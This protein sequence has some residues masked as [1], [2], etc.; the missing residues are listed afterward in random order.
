MRQAQLA[1]LFVLPLPNEGA[2]DASAVVLIMD[3]GK[4]N[5]YGRIDYGGCMRAKNASEC[6]HN[7]LAFSL[8]QRFHI[9]NEP[10]P[11]FQRR[12]N[13][14]HFHL[15][16]HEERTVAMQYNNH[17]H[18]MKRILGSLDIHTSKKT[19]LNRGG[20]ARHAEDSGASEGDIRRAGRWNVQQ[21]Q[22]CYLT[23]LP[24]KA[25]RALA[26]FPT[27][28][29]A[30]HL[31]RATINP[32]PAL[33]NK[34][35][36]D[37]EGA[38]LGIEQG[39][40]EKDLAAQG[41][42]RLLVYLRTVLVQDAVVMRKQFSQH[43]IFQHTIFADPLFIDYAKNLE[44]ALDKNER[45]LSV[46]VQE[47]LPEAHR[48]LLDMQRDQQAAHLVTQ[49]TNSTILQLAGLVQGAFTSI[50][51][52]VD[53]LA[54]R[55]VKV[56]VHIEQHQQRTGSSPVAVAALAQSR[57]DRL[58]ITSNEDE[59]IEHH[60]ESEQQQQRS[61]QPPLLLPSP[62]SS[63][64][65]QSPAFA[66][67]LRGAAAAAE[68]E[69][70]TVPIFQQSRAL[71]SIVHVWQEYEKGINHGP[72]VRDLEARWQHKWRTD[73]KSRKFFSQRNKIYAKVMRLAHDKRVT[74][75]QAA[76]ALENARVA[77]KRSVDWCQKNADTL[78]TATISCLR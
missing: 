17:Y 55:E 29:G 10:F 33:L 40:L 4:T 70:E 39:R 45:P 76:Q 54:N 28:P 20:A 60:V 26:G 61:E 53:S 43:P 5:A 27:K 19:H 38:L 41:F 71:T 69:E 75:V 49:H 16:V 67:P 13:W 56:T 25:M 1:D 78:F 23:G 21:M 52:E 3:N 12:E 74:E 7:A 36:P 72:A 2:Q 64:P 62:S 32:P 8:F 42:L 46:S 30:Y 68:T 18:I 9:D 47:I 77:L 51:N 48:Y 11:T 63:L 6:P 73:T 14:Y 44:V 24:R 66:L 31:P 58:S 22:G 59:N 65:S 34:I 35:W 57:D 37:V 15:L 50:L